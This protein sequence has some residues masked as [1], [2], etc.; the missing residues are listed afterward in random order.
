MNQKH[1][2]VSWKDSSG[3]GKS[4]GGRDMFLRLGPGSNIVRL[5]TDPFQYYQHKYKIPGDKGYG[6][7]IA[8]S[9]ANGVCAV[10]KKGDKPKRRWLIGVI[11]RKT[12]TYKILDIGWS[13]FKGIKT[14]AED[15][16]WGDPSRYD[17]DI[18]V[19]PNGGATNYYTVVAKPA[20]PLSANDLKL[21][22]ENGIDEL[23]KRTQSPDPDKVEQRLQ[24]LLEE[25]AGTSD[26]SAASTPNSSSSTSDEDDEFPAFDDAASS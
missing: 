26:N 9:G 8:C 17:I 10:C 14:Y 22:D 6:H 13:V 20:K 24:K 23:E 1:G 4:E 19:D 18:V 7:R 5:V 15:E 21:R 2:Q 3:G 12:S 11:D 16:D 25:F